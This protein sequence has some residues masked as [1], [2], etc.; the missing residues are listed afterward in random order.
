MGER[1]AGPG[2]GRADAVTGGTV[3][4]EGDRSPDDPMS[5]DRRR[6]ATIRDVAHLAGVSTATVSRVLAGVGRPRAE[7]AAAVIAAATELAYRPSGVARSLRLRRTR[8]LGLIVTDIQNP[9]FPEL[10]QAAELAARSVGY[11][12]LLGSAAYDEQRA[13]HYLDLMADSRVDGMIVA[14]SQLSEDSWH[15]LAQAPIPVV[16]VN[17]EPSGLPITVITSDNEG[18]ARAAATHLIGLGH[19]RMAYIRGDKSFTADPPRFEGFR[20]VCREAGIPDI[21]LVELHGDGRFEGGERAATMLL[22]SGVHVTAIATHN[23][24][25]AIGAMR[26]LRHLDVR[27]PRDMSVIGCDD[28]AA[29]AWIVPALTTISQQKAEMGRTAV[30]RI[31]AMLDDPDRAILPETIRIPTVIR[32]RESTGPAP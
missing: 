2:G 14:T 10:V 22:D 31:T 28:I 21:D 27:V 29:A 18:G 16:V 4:T 8:T 17:A 26:A 5:T 25:T 11:S 23:D 20:A 30:E 32:V 12:I 13:I 15:W 3:V 1:A 19:R 6:A 24:M 9:F 7:T